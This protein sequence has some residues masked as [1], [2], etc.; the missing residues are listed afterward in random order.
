MY[1]IFILL[2]VD[3]RLEPIWLKSIKSRLVASTNR[4]MV[5][6]CLYI[7]YQYDINAI[8]SSRLC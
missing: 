5:V 6:N 4:N 7:N 2:G 3:R 8:T 1:A